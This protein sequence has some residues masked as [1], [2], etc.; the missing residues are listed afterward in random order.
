MNAADPNF[1]P[2]LE[3]ALSQDASDDLNAFR[4]AF[5]I[6]DPDL[7]YLDGNS[8]G[9]P[10]RSTASV[11]EHSVNRAWGDRLIRSWGEGWYDA[12]WRV[13]D[14]I[15][16]LI[17]AGPGQVVVS[18]STSVNLYKLTQAALALRPDRHT[19][20]SDRLNFPSDIYIFQGC[21]QARGQGTR[22]RLADEA[23]DPT[24]AVLAAMDE[25]TALVSLS[26]VAFK[27]GC[28]VDAAAV[29]QRAH[30]VG[31]L[32]LW[33]LSHAAG[34]VPVELDAWQADFAVGCSYKYLN[35]GPG[36][37][38]FLYVNQALQ[39]QAV[40]P[41]WGW[42]GEDHPFA[43]DLE[44][45]PAQ[46]IRRFL[47]GT[48]PILAIAAMEP[49]IDLLLAAGMERIRRKSARLT[50]Y[51]VDLYHHFLSPL[52][53]SLG[54]PLDPQTRGSHIA[55]RHPEGY[56]ITQALIREEKVVPDF[57]EPD[58]LRFGIAPLYNSYLDIWEAVRRTARV[59]VEKRYLAYTN[60]RGTV[61]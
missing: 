26:L 6:P 13:G 4:E 34:A 32:V 43:F 53:F 5:L 42:F 46:G 37:P 47:A 56:R 49:G 39:A 52:G 35:G 2:T 30:Q 22:V 11:L 10:P 58:L 9:R 33:D 15:G 25:D 23:D 24:A 7:I 41:I 20:L 54:S 45:H 61:T 50:T 12:P 18:D 44:Y 8:L 28:L 48:P 38:A 51:L 1:C 55:L 31:A 59:V 17:G 27:S 40:S 21:A 29:T 57:R 14:K 60:T 16:Q 3:Y 36:A 19:I